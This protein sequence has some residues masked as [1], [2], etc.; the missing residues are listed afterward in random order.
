MPDNFSFVI[1]GR[2]AGMARPGRS[3]PLEDDLAFLMAQGIGAIVSMTESSLMENVDRAGATLIELK[4]LGVRL[5]LDDFGTG[6]SSLAY[7][8]QFPIDKLKIDQSFVRGLPGDADDAAIAC[9]I[10]IPNAS[11]SVSRSRVSLA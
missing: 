8:K 6:Y 7:L 9:T 1:E 11:V 3:S 5:S 10:R 4:A 2:L